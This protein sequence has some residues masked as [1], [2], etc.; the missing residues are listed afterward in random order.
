MSMRDGSKKAY[1]I[2]LIH[3]EGGE[4]R[5]FTVNATRK[6]DHTKKMNG[7]YFFTLG[8]EMRVEMVIVSTCG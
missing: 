1:I 4:R 5:F 3:K 8:R 6:R 2:I 7:K